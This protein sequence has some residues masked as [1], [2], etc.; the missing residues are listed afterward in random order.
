MKLKITKYFLLAIVAF[1]SFFTFGY[2]EKSVDAQTCTR[3]TPGASQCVSGSYCQ[4]NIYF[5]CEE[6]GYEMEGP[7]DT[8]GNICQP[9]SEPVDPAEYRWNNQCECEQKR[10]S[11]RCDDT[12]AYGT[13]EETDYWTT[14]GCR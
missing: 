11:F 6:G 5:N 13:Y 9:P 1:F 8:D 10:T 14:G 4:Q 2:N 7:I 3:I 12:T